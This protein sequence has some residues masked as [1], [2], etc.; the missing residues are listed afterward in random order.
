MVSK[1]I[2]SSFVEAF[3]RAASQLV[4]FLQAGSAAEGN[5]AMLFI[6]TVNT[7]D[8]RHFL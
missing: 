3:T 2:L 6:G 5:E 1:C 8:P 7:S 4:E